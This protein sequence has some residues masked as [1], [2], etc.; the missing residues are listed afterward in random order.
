MMLPFWGDVPDLP[1]TGAI[2]EITM[3]HYKTPISRATWPMTAGEVIDLPAECLSEKY[4]RY[5][6]AF[7]S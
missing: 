5:S 7:Q 6:S 1:V 2:E 4:I 3:R